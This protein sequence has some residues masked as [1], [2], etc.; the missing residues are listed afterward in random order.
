MLPYQDRKR[1][2]L[3]LQESL[4]IAEEAGVL[5]AEVANHIRSVLTL[6]WKGRMAR[7]MGTALYR[8]HS[9]TICLSK[10][11]WK[12][13]PEEQKRE[14]VFHEMAHI[15]VAARIA[16]D[17]IRAKLHR[18]RTRNSYH[19]KDWI[20][21]MTAI[22]YKNPAR[23]HDVWNGEHE[24]RR[25][26][27]ALYCACKSEPKLWIKPTRALDIV[28]KRLGCATCKV[29]FRMTAAPTSTFRNKEDL[30]SAIMAVLNG[31]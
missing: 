8:K 1:A 7:T 13:A 22:G 5:T 12:A 19:G 31:E 29:A 21:V 26:N 28:R 4:L 25:G 14:T 24:K 9:A 11:L 2:M 15:I 20:R 27:V 18:N 10:I 23:C 17:P 30:T 16:H 6:E 3:W